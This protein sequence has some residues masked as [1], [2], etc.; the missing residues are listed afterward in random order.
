MK[1]RRLIILLLLS[2][3][4]LALA[5]FAGNLYFSGFE[6]RLRTA[7]F[8]KILHEKEKIMDECL[9]GLRM[10]L[11]RGEAHGSTPVTNLF[12]LAQENE[13]TILEYLDDK[14]IYWSDNKFDVPLYLQDDS[15]FSEPVVFFQNGWFVPRI[16]R[17]GNERIMGL[18]KIRT[19]FSLEND[20]IRSGFEEDFRIPGDAE[21]NISREV[22]PYNI[23]DSGGRFLFSLVFPR[24]KDNSALIFFPLVLWVIFLIMILVLCTEVM[25]YF[26]SRGKNTAGII[27]CIAIY[28]SIYIFVLL[29][30]RPVV[31]FETA[32]FAPRIFH[33]NRFIPSLGHLM[34]LSV[35]AAL[36]VLLL[37]KNLPTG[38]L[39]RE[40]RTGAGSLLLLAGI[41]TVSFFHV[42]FSRLVSGSAI[43]FETYKVTGLDYYSVAAFSVIIIL[44][45]IPLFFLTRLSRPAREGTTGRFSFQAVVLIAVVALIFHRD[46]FS[47]VAIAAYSAACLLFARVTARRA[48]G[49]FNRVVI[50]SLILG[51]YSLV[52]ITWFSG[53]KN[54]ENIKIEALSLSVDNDPE[55][56]QLLLDM[57]PVIDNDKVLDEMM[58]TGNFL[59]NDQ[60]KISGYLDDAYLNGYWKNYNITKIE[61]RDDGDLYLGPGNSSIVNCFDFFDEWIRGHGR[62]LTGTGFYF[63]DNQAGRSYYLGKL[64]FDRPDGGMNGL[65]IELYSDVNVFYRGYSELLLDKKF[66]GY[67]HLREYSFAKF[68]NGIKVFESGEFA[69]NNTDD[70]YVDKNSNYRLF[71]SGGFRHVLYRNGNATVIISNP[72]LTAGNVIISFAYLFAFILIF[73]N[74]LYLLVGQGAIRNAWSMNFRQ[75]LQVSFAGILFFSF[76]LVS[77]IVI[78]LTIKDYRSRHHENLKE[79]LNSVYMEMENKLSMEIKITPGWS[80]PSYPSLEALLVRLSNTF[81]TDINIYSTGGQLISTSRPEIFYRDLMSHRM[82]I[83]AFMN[84]KDLTRNESVQTEKIGSMEYIS[85]YTP[86]YSSGNMVQAYLNLPYFRMQSTLTREISNMVVVVINITLLLILVTMSLAVIISKRLTSPLSMLG[87]GLASVRLGKKSE[88]LEYT[89]SDEIGELVKQYN[90]MVDELEES[91]K[92]LADSEREHA[93]REMAKQIAHE[94]KNPLTPMKL[95]VQ[96][97]LKSW[98]DGTIDFNDKLEGFSRNQIEYIDNLSSIASAFSSFARMPGT[99]PAE[100]DV[101]EQLETTLDLFRNAD[102]IAFVV[103]WPR[104]RKVIIFADREHLKGIFSNLLKNSIQAI[105]PG[106]RGL[107]RVTVEVQ[108]NKVVIS[109]SDNGRGIPESVRGRL[110]TPN[111][112]TKTSGTGLGLSIVKKYVEDARGRIWFE[113]EA[114]KGT[115]FHVEFPLKYTVEKHD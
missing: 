89:G 21:L 7:R 17:A 36:T 99:N 73:L 15:L 101:L 37:Y 31:V 43:C 38:R 72:A 8:A 46:L 76:I 5:I 106:G 20:F 91:A 96:Q 64:L 82:N 1:N 61:C 35:L 86:L 53:K 81:N 41:V 103:D 27:T 107:I 60:K 42:V 84:L 48:T 111:F 78:Q 67:Q 51:L 83:R 88:H 44:S 109:V 2:F 10:I 65:F 4:A 97:L 50:F 104:E 11:A 52:M 100:V 26:S 19:E 56:E 98:R 113:S 24:E 9:K 45:V 54:I 6:Y 32:L 3:V 58:S 14:L 79:K 93:W 95:N 110:F 114:G 115:V 23:F 55:A 71:K 25:N 90:R 75:K 22:S 39:N 68:I 49:V 74:L 18:L 92:K 85:I 87:N 47:L 69:Y 63:M 30:K 59:P 70:D 57:W 66:R 112:T 108:G 102:N 33:M 80:N 12:R 34:L 77:I 13:I 40:K 16:I 105:Q 94:I 28:S 62:Q 29:A